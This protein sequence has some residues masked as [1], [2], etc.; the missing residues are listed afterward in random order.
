MVFRAWIVSRV[1]SPGKHLA[2]P[3]WSVCISATITG[4]QKLGSTHGGQGLLA[5]S[6][7]RT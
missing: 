4:R 5:P 3:P 2:A 1:A 6:L 7:L